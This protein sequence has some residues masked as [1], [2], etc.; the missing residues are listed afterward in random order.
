MAIKYYTHG[1]RDEPKIAL[2]FDDGPN[3]PRTEQI[4]SILAADRVR[5]TFFVIGKWVDRFPRTVDRIVAGG[6]VVGNQSYAHLLHIGDYDRAEATIAHVTG[7][8]SRYARAHLFDIAACV[9]SPVINS[10]DV[11]LVFAD[12]NPDD[13]RCR[14]ARE[15]LD[16]VL[17]HPNLTNGSIIDLHDGAEYEDDQ[18]RLKRPLP[19]IEALPALIRTLRERGYRLV[20]LDEMELVEPQVW[21]PTDEGGGE[22]ENRDGSSVADEEAE[23]LWR[24]PGQWKP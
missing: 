1:R 17:D 7:H 4:L 13:W 8:P 20:S 10:P 9:Q 18:A 23:R 6:H 16:A 19:L 15:V 11:K 5:A 21:S 2:T 14:T 24:A 12:V 22:P 3:P